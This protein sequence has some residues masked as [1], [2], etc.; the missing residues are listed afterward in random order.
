MRMWSFLNPLKIRKNE[1]CKTQAS[2]LLQKL[3]Y[4]STIY[5]AD[6]YVRQKKKDSPTNL[7]CRTVPLKKTPDKKSVM[8]L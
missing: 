1:A 8:L 2:F 5:G 6:K 3:C 4:N 7:I